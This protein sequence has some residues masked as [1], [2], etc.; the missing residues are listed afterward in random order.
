[1]RRIL[2]NTLL[3]LVSM[4]VALVAGDTALRLFSSVAPRSGQFIPEPDNFQRLT[5]RTATMSPLYRGV[6]NG[7]DFSEIPIHTNRL[8]FRDEEHDPGLLAES[9][10]ILFLGDSY[11]FGWGVRR[12]QRVSELFA[13]ELRR[14]AIDAPVINMAVA[15]T[16]TYQALDLL[17]AFGQPLNPRLVILGFFVGNDFLDNQAAAAIVPDLPGLGGDVVP[18]LTLVDA[19]ERSRALSLRELLRTSP[20]FNLVKYGLW[21]SS[22]FRRLFNRLEI[23]NDRI[24][25]YTAQ[26]DDLFNRLYGPSLKALQEIAQ[27]TRTEGIPMLV[28]IIPDQ[29][30]VLEPQLFE[31]YDSLKPQRIL[32]QH[33]AK[34]GIPYLDLLPVFTSAPDPQQLFFREDK[35]W[36]RVGHALVARAL[37]PPAISILTG[38]TGN[39]EHRREPEVVSHSSN[40]TDR[41]K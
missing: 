32:S 23:Q 11:V 28:L 7:R 15:G 40:D 37:A 30:Q 9:R 3:V 16:G 14:H 17:S 12:E 10:P 6:L 31:D 36:S 8:G 39:S 24:A 38:G 13:D 25:L 41:M 19:S 2:V 33:L 27:L 5:V 21:E 18:S 4:V 22:T 20:V 1:M 34:L 26:S 29:L 35:H